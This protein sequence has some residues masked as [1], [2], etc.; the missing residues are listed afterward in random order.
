MGADLERLLEVEGTQWS[1]E[2]FE[3]A[4]MTYE[5]G[6]KLYSRDEGDVGGKEAR[7]GETRR[8]EDEGRLGEYKE[9]ETGGWITERGK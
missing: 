1:E 4:W 9:D 6:V 2:G 3:I 8:S 5:M 7:E